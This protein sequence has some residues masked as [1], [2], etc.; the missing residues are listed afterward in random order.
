LVSPLK[1]LAN[2]LVFFPKHW[3]SVTCSSSPVGLVNI[4]MR[5]NKWIILLISS[6][7]IFFYSTA[8]PTTHGMTNRVVVPARQWESIPG[9]L[10]RF[11][12]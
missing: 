11:E 9:I 8:H 3:F 1:F 7:V 6:L 12:G 4:G 2:N 5:K 10:K